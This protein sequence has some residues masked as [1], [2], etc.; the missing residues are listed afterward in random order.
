[1]KFTFYHN[2]INVFNLEKSI[3]FYQKALGLTITKEKEAEDGSFKLVF[4]GDEV[5]PHMLELTWLRDMDRPYNLG[6]NEIHLAMQVDDMDAA[7]AFHKE[8]N[9]I[10]FDNQAMGVYFISDPDGYWIEICK[11]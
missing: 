5:T 4:L 1:M 3:E 9:C 11:K 2:N 8:M 7:Y 6:D 10:C